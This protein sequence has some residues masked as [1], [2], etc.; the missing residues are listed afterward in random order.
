MSGWPKP[1]FPCLLSVGAL[2]VLK[3]P[4]GL[5]L[6]DRGLLILLWGGLRTPLESCQITYI[7]GGFPC[8]SPQKGDSKAM[9]GS[10]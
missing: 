2:C 7:R 10:V 9:G 4:K 3:E 5:L 8:H 6:G 1:T